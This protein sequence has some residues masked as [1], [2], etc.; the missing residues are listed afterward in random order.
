[1]TRKR[2]SAFL[3]ASALLL[4]F[5]TNVV[6]ADGGKKKQTILTSGDYQ[7]VLLEDGSAELLYCL[8]DDAEIVIPDTLDG[9][10]VTSID[11]IS[12]S[13]SLTAVTIPNSV[14]DLDHN[15]FGCCPLLQTISVAPEHPSF[16]TLDGV[17]FRKKDDALVAYPRGKA[18]SS[19]A[20]P[21]GTSAVDERAFDCCSFLTSVSLPASVTEIDDYAFSDCSA[22]VEV[23]IPSSV[24]EIGSCAFNYCTA[25]SSIVIP[26]SVTEIEEGAFS[27]CRA[28]TTV[29][30]PNSLT[31]ISDYLFSYCASLSSILIPDSVTEIETGA[32]QS[33]TALVS[34]VIPDSVTEIEDI[35]F[36]QCSALRSVLL[37]ASVTEIGV[38]AFDKCPNLTLTVFRNSYAE[39]YAQRNH[40]PYTYAD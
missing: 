22:L 25:L 31:E 8:S 4:V 34:I 2:F 19:Y 18:A 35:A 40:I 1:M 33:C 26:D 7:Y 20:V 11:T 12:F 30:L 17:L 38:G 39:R 23:S 3:L 10:R 36:S 21:Q 14:V 24:D 15:P 27:E 9:H 28:L 5:L 37:P 16:Y 29:V 32:F 6:F 13:L